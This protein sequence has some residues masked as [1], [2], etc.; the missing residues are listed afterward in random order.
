V[1]AARGGA[2]RARAGGA[3]YEPRLPVIVAGTRRIFQ[4]VD[5]LS[6]GGS[7]GIGID[8]TE[9]EAM[10]A[11]IARM[12]EAHR[13]TL[14]QLATGLAIFSADA[15]LEFYNAAYRGLWG[16]EPAFL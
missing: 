11:G 1:P 7:A 16:L 2:F 13:R 8:V 3:P 12:I 4:V 6:P 14:D 10:R 9:V 15:R 5:R